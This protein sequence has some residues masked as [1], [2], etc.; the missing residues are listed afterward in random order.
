[1][2][3]NLNKM[4]PALMLILLNPIFSQIASAAEESAA[5]APDTFQSAESKP[6]G[7]Q[8]GRHHKQAALPDSIEKRSVVI[9]SDGTRM[10]AD[11]YLPKGLKPDTKLPAVIFC[12]G[13]AGTKD[14]TPSRL[15]PQFVEQGYAF[16]A[17]D[18]RGWG[19]SDSR[20][21]L[22]DPLPAPGPN[23]DAM[24]HVRPIRWQLDFADQTCDI[25]SAISFLSGEPNVDAN[26]IGIM[27][28]SY[29][30]GLVTWVAANDPRVKCVVAQVPGMGGNKGAA[31]I[32]ASYA[33]A[34][35]QA[36]GETEPVPHETGKLGGNMSRF[37][38]M[39]RN[40][41][42]SIGYNPIDAASKINIPMLIVVAEKD[43]LVDNDANGK[44]VYDIVNSKGNV[45]VAYHMIKDITHFDVYTKGMN[46]AS[47]LELKWYDDHLK[48]APKA[49]A[50]ESNRVQ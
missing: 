48:N 33:L 37:A 47:T 5:S 1:M 16:L 46:E 36:R 23:G 17:F 15:A 9:W 21:M 20:L 3:A 12:N 31:A 38:Q 19:N 2:I 25:R 29:G 26:R 40:P 32:A 6:A 4:M 18:Y 45:P 27:G 11:L 22:V 28:S 30:G 50:L 39:R 42:K 24:A 43:E 49:V 14:G 34:T 7:H 13:T 10:A 41:A 44:A 8:N 35:K